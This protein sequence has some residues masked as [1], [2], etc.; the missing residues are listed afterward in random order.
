MSSESLPLSGA[1][2]AAPVREEAP[3]DRGYDYGFVGRSVAEA[4]GSFLLVFVGVAVAIFATGSGI[5]S[6]LAFGLAL[7]AAMV[8]FGYISGGHFNPAIT[9]GS[10]VAGRTAWKYVLP[11]IVAQLVGALAGVAILWVAINGHSQFGAQTQEFML[12]ASNGF[13]DN[14][15]TAFPLPSAL[16]LEVIAG[17]LLT[18]VFLGATARRFGAV[19]SAFA[20]GVTYAVLLTM[21]APVTGG[22]INPAR[23]TA[24]A[25]F[26][27]STSLEQL[28]LFWAAPLLGAVIAGLIFLSVDMTVQSRLAP[29]AAADA[30][31]DEAGAVH[32]TA[33][34]DGPEAAAAQASAPAA[35]TP[36]KPADSRAGGANP[37]V[38]EEARGFFDKPSATDGG[39]RRADG[40]DA[41]GTPGTRN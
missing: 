28:W 25:I 37:A 35:T 11:Y 39:A 30:D 31:A 5:T 6:P 8:A 23:S 24:T 19:G 33:A 20:V 12:S 9:L 13:G 2:A 27:G 36:V 18:A 38:D 1:R 7:A 26:A 21:L 14:S 32:E 3:I 16:L 29:S 15:P 40:D 10:A 17:A 4:I 22:G 34:V 41:D